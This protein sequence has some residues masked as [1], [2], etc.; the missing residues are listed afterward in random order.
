MC[1]LGA[2][3]VKWRN[4]AF[5]MPPILVSNCLPDLILAKYV[6]ASKRHDALNS[7]RHGVIIYVMA[8]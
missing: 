1:L 7:W 4:S 5:L 8:S 2:L 6:M 3:S